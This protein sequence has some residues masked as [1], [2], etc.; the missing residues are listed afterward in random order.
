MQFYF[1]QPHSMEVTLKWMSL[2]DLNGTLCGSLSCPLLNHTNGFECLICN[3]SSSIHHLSSQSN[4]KLFG[5]LKYVHCYFKKPNMSTIV[6]MDYQYLGFWLFHWTIIGLL[7]KDWITLALIFKNN[8]MHKIRCEI[9]T[10]F[11]NTWNFNK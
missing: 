8:S 2:M 7:I 11:H 4:W 10:P 1:I 6:R 9:F 5:I 3:L